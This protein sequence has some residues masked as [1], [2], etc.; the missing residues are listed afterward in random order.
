[1]NISEASVKYAL[2]ENHLKKRRSHL[3]NSANMNLSLLLER[4]I[5]WMNLKA[6]VFVIDGLSLLRAKTPNMKAI[7]SLH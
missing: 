6:L 5:S 4:K 1:M 2:E 7:E 3:Q